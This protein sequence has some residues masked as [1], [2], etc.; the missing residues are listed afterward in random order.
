M[1]CLTCQ[2]QVRSPG[3]CWAGPVDV[4]IFVTAGTNAAEPA[5]HLTRIQ[6]VVPG[7][8]APGS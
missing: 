4:C 2:G 3:R 7:S 5:Q 8:R 1:N 6:L